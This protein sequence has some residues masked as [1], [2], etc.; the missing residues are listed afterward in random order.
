MKEWDFR[1]WREEL[2]NK[3]SAALYR[4]SRPEIQEEKCYDNQS[5]SVTFFSGVEPT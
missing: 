5:S 4:N 2:L 1:N 3:R